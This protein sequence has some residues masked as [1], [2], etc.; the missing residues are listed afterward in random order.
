MNYMFYFFF[1]F[2]SLPTVRFFFVLENKE[3]AKPDDIN[4]ISN[5]QGAEYSMQT[6]FAK[7]VLL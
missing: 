2:H 1:Q 4:D 5:F 6:V 3:N 7:R